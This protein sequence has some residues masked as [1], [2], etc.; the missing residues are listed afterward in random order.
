[1]PPEFRDVRF[2]CG[3]SGHI[4]VRESGYPWR[5]TLT[6]LVESGDAGCSSPLDR[7]QVEELHRRLGHWLAARS[8]APAKW[9]DL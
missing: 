6:V 1:M 9:E 8:K 5:N 2:A 7:D 3:F 4:V